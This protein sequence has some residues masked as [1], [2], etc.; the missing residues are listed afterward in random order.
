M[1]EG[2]TKIPLVESE[3]TMC[4]QMRKS[5]FLIDTP[6]VL[7]GIDERTIRVEDKH[8]RC[9]FCGSM[10]HH[11]SECDRWRRSYACTWC[12]KI[13]SHLSEVCLKNQK[14]DEIRCLELGLLGRM[15][16]GEGPSVR[17]PPYQVGRVCQQNGE[18]NK[19]E[20]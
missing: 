7:K 14:A 12:G 17:E 11:F 8:D 15:D 2:G 20:E 3:Y 4:F 19:R 6:P 18:I 5:E 10:Q 16:I 1:I 13:E 9:T